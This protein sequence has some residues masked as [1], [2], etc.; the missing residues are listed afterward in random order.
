MGDIR[1]NIGSL[2]RHGDPNKAQ[3]PS[4]HWVYKN[5]FIAFTM[6]SDGAQPERPNLIP[7]ADYHTEHFIYS[8]PLYETDGGVGHHFAMC[9]CG[10]EA[11]VIDRAT[12]L[13]L[14]HEFPMN[15]PQLVVCKF[16]C[17]ELAKTGGR[18]GRHQ[19]SFINKREVERGRLNY[20]Q[21]GSK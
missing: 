10:S 20:S 14:N 3:L 4:G 2:I 12:A 9:T 21:K 1:K 13:R 18:Q 19:T 7:A 15:A 6:P 8:D 5:P 16:Y 11:V 17:D